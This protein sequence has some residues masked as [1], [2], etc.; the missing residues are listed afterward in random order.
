[1]QHFSGKE[2]IKKKLKNGPIL[3]V[4][5]GILSLE[6]AEKLFEITGKAY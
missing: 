3:K 4:F 1:M 6:N 5:Y 2:D